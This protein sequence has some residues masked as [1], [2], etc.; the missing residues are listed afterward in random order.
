MA[1]AGRANA[2]AVLLKTPRALSVHC[3][4][5]VSFISCRPIYTPIYCCCCYTSWECRIFASLR[6]FPLSAKERGKRVH[7]RSL[8]TPP[9]CLC[10]SVCRYTCVHLR[11]C[12]RPASSLTLGSESEREEEVVWARSGHARKEGEQQP[13]KNPW[14]RRRAVLVTSILQR[15]LAEQAIVETPRESYSQIA[16]AKGEGEKRERERARGR[17]PERWDLSEV[18]PGPN[19]VTLA[20]RR[21]CW[22]CY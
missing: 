4:T 20:R 14:L 21:R 13:A 22:C 17:A 5:A 9:H 1:S 18:L 6:L 8:F 12:A 10:A 19:W 7:I 2:P 15:F 11:W 16:L 3:H